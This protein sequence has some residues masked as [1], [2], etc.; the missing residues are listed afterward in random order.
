MLFRSPQAE[1]STRSRSGDN[2]GSKLTETDV[3]E[4]VLLQQLH[5]Q[6]QQAINDV[7]DGATDGLSARSGAEIQITELG[8]DADCL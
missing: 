6:E 7:S 4:L 2:L 3:V 8:I 5:G 1:P